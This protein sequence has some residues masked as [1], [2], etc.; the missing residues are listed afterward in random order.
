MSQTN[1]F[2]EMFE[3]F[4]KSMGQFQP[5]SMP[6]VDMDSIMKSGQANM[7]A[8]T[9]AGRIAVEGMQTLASRQQEM[10][11]EAF[12][13]FQE[14]AKGITSGDASEMMSKPVEVAR[15]RFEKSVANF[16]ELAEIA[17]KS[18]T[19][20]WSVIGRRWQE[21]VSNLQKTAG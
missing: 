10:L 13:D 20:A 16:R 5:T 3:S 14:S 7:D 4:T 8:V 19:E 15:E 9:E 11:T 2:N 17:G 18:Q 6:S 1:P 21:S 12:T